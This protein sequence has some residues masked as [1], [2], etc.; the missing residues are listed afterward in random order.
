MDKDGYD[1]IAI[2]GEDICKSVSEQLSKGVTLLVSYTLISF[3]GGTFN[4]IFF[5]I[6]FWIPAGIYWL[7][8]SRN[9]EKDMT[10]KSRILSE[11]KQLSL[12]DYIFELEVQMDRAIQKV[13]DSKY[14]ITSDIRKF[15]KLLDEA[16]NIYK[17]LF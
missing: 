1:T 7:L 9:V 5:S 6:F 16:I 3:L 17:L 15:N 14:Y 13:Q 12:I 4:M 10:Y 8:A 2:T 11:R